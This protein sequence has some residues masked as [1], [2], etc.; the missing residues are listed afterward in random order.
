[1]PFLSDDEVTVG[2]GEIV[3]LSLSLLTP[4]NGNFLNSYSPLV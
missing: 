1:M 3:E 4:T 2:I